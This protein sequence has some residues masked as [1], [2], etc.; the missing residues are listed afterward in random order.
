[1][2][3]FRVVGLVPS[4]LLGKV[5]ELMISNQIPVTDL[6]LVE[7][8]KES[9]TKE[10]IH[11]SNI[12]GQLESPQPRKPKRKKTLGGKITPIG[13]RVRELFE[14]FSDSYKRPFYITELKKAIKGQ[15]PEMTDSTFW[16]VRKMMTQKKVVFRQADG[17]YVNKA[18]HQSMKAQENA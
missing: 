10:I 15:I 13:R 5:M 17:L 1:M 6:D 8:T 14:E 12:Q 7:I 3:T 11:L 9:A 4:E 2:G 18:V 16:Y